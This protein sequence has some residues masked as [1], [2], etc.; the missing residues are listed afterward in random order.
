[1]NIHSQ[2]GIRTRNQGL[3]TTEDCSGL[4]PLGYR[5]RHKHCTILQIHVIFWMSLHS[6]LTSCKITIKF[7]EVSIITYSGLWNCEVRIM[8]LRFIVLLSQTSPKAVLFSSL[9]KQTLN[10]EHSH[11]LCFGNISDCSSSRQ[12][13]ELNYYYIADT[14]ILNTSSQ[15]YHDD[16]FSRSLL[17]RFMTFLS[18]A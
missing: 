6:A 11:I 4:R 18:S 2:G 5:D 14:R 7:L 17:L 16:Y 15:I 1:L 13:R 9:R 12:N 3:R 10:S 8:I